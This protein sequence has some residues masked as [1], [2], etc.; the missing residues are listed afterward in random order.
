MAG[1]LI[2]SFEV[3]GEPASKSRPR[4]TSK[5]H[6]YTPAAVKQAEQMI[7]TAFRAAGGRLMND[8]NVAFRVEAEFHQGTHQRRD[9][10]NMLKLVLDGLNKIAWPDDAQVLDVRGRKRFVDR[11]EAKTIVSVYA[12]GDMGRRAEECRHCG[13]TFATYPSWNN[14]GR[15]RVFCSRDCTYAA[16]RAQRTHT[17]EHCGSDFIAR[18]KAATPRFCST[19]CKNQHGMVTIACVVCGVDFRQYRSWAESRRCCSPECSQERARTQR[20]ERASSRFPGTCAIC[21]AGTTRKEYR[22]C[23]PCKLDGK[24]IPEEAV[25][26]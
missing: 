24:P 20:A 25:A 26:S 4:F 10:D 9:V 5:G 15:R 6:V 8:P 2:A 23:N 19:A 22:R 16:S 3:P 21:G 17:C 11:P 14:P 12:D 7:A 13:R 18:A 1:T